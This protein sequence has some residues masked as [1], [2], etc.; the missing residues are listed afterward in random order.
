MAR[1][2][3]KAQANQNSTGIATEYRRLVYIDKDL[4]EKFK[5]IAPDLP[6][7]LDLN[8]LSPAAAKELVQ[9]LTVQQ[10]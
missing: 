1:I 2:R 9:M 7:W 6:P 10:E 3:Q 5:Q 8:T 4:K